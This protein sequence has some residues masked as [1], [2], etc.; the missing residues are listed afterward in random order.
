VGGAR[1]FVEHV[2]NARLPKELVKVGES[3]VHAFGFCLT[4]AHLDGGNGAPARL[5]NLMERSALVF[6]RSRPSG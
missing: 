1:R 5:K 3:R 2:L 6:E 4:F